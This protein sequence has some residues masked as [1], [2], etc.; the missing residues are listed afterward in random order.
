MCCGTNSG[1]SCGLV[2]LLRTFTRIP[3]PTY[4]FNFRFEMGNPGRK[5]REKINEKE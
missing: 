2:L 5:V 1:T 4:N 3:D